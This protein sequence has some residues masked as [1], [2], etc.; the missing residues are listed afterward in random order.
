MQLLRHKYYCLTNWLFAME[1]SNHRGK[2][3]NMVKNVESETSRIQSNKAHCSLK[4][5]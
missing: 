2:Q 4:A 1:L 5:K 3:K